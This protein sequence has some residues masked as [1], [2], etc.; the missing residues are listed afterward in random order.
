MCTETMHDPNC[1]GCR[2]CDDFSTRESCHRLCDRPRAIQRLRRRTVEG[3][4]TYVVRDADLRVY[5]REL[6]R[7]PKTFLKNRRQS[8]ASEGTP[9]NPRQ[10]MVFEDPSA[11]AAI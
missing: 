2:A 9:E 11:S 5:A 7:W 8:L 1:Q 4:Q 3:T 6:K 10:S